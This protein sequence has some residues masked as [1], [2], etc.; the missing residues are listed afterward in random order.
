MWLGFQSGDQEVFQYDGKT[1]K[2]YLVESEKQKEHEAPLTGFDYNRKLGIVVTSC[3]GGSIRIWSREKKFKREIIFPH[4]IDSVCF[5]NARGD[6]LVSHDKRVSQILYQR[7]KTKTFE[8][9]AK[10]PD[11]IRLVEVND[12]LLEELR[13]KDDAVRGKKVMKVR[14]RSQSKKLKKGLSPR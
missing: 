1:Q 6:L 7:Y 10:Y 3:E 2:F 4:R 14:P 12:E 9:F 13:E 11:P 8:F 5:A